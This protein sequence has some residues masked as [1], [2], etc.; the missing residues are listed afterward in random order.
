MSNAS[1]EDQI[2]YSEIFKSMQGEGPYTG[3]N[4]LWIR[5]YGCNLQCQGFGQAIP[6]DPSTWSSTFNALEV[7]DIQNLSEY[8]PAEVGCD[9]PY[10]WDPRVK[11]LQHSANP[12]SIERELLSLTSTNSLSN[13]NLAFT[14]GEPLIPTGQRAIIGILTQ[15]ALNGNLPRRITFETNST[16]HLSEAFMSQLSA[17]NVP[18]EFSMSPKMLHVS[19]ESANKAQKPDVCAQYISFLQMPADTIDPITH[20]QKASFYRK[21]N[22]YRNSSYSFKFVWN[23][24]NESLEE[25]QA[26]VKRVESLVGINPNSVWIMPVGATQ[27]QQTSSSTIEIIDRILNLEYNVALR[28]HVYVYGDQQGT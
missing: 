24:E 12:A 23:G 17:F 21:G 13:W 11:K 9:T 14:G 6:G 10:S 28:A 27:N 7:S 25:I 4:T 22:F 1:E 5:L 16:R 15:L 26:F 8:P 19:G 18:V 20:T 2:R 3:E